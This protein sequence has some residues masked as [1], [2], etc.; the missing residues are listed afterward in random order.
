MQPFGEMVEDWTGSSAMGDVPLSAR[1]R[2]VGPPR[3]GGHATPPR[4]EHHRCSQHPGATRPPGAARSAP[5]TER[6][7][8]MRPARPQRELF[9]GSD[10]VG[11]APPSAALKGHPPS[12][13]GAGPAPRSP[14]PPVRSL[15]PGSTPGARQPPRRHWLPGRMRCAPTAERGRVAGVGQRSHGYPERPV[16]STCRGVWHALGG[17]GRT[18]VKA[19]ALLQP[20]VTGKH[21]ASIIQ[22]RRHRAR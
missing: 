5:M 14:V 18:E 4:P 8:G 11:V 17:A 15:L 9:G 12:G 20:P 16:V 21:A 19:P 2:L 10:R 6:G 3:P 13:R 7:R 22:P 1:A